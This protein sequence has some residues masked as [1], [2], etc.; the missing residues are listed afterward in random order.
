MTFFLRDPG[1]TR[2]GR[3]VQ[4]RFR[5][6][7]ARLPPSR[8]GRLG[9]SLALQVH[10]QEPTLIQG[11]EFLRIKLTDVLVSSFQTGGNGGSDLL[12]TDQVSLNFAKI[13]YGYRAQKSD[14]TLEAAVRADWDVKANCKAG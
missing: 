8:G 10:P 6:W 2:R 12:P 4:S 14:G 7:R 3:A 13:E 1:R 5:P 9:G 11:P